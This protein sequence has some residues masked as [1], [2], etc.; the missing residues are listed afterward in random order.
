MIV[1]SRMFYEILCCGISFVVHDLCCELVFVVSVWQWFFRV[2]LI[3][4]ESDKEYEK[5]SA[6]KILEILVN[7]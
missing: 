2:M 3:Q 5:S 6:L 4:S 7:A 1:C